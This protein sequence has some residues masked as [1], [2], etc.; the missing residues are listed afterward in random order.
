MHFFE[1]IPGLEV[2]GKKKYVVSDVPNRKPVVTGYF[3]D[4]DQLDGQYPLNC[5]DVLRRKHP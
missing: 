2:S 5:Q 3:G 4:T 1:W